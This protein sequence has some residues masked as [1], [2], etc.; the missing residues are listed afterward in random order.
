M[1]EKKEYPKVLSVPGDWSFATV[2]LCVVFALT[3]SHAAGVNL[4]LSPSR[5]ST[6]PLPGF[7]VALSSSV[8]ISRMF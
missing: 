8:K 7:S 4:S 1:T 2:C 6:V 3:T 5:T